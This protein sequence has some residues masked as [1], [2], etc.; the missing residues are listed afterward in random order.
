MSKNISRKEFFKTFK[1]S[2]SAASERD[3]VLGSEFTNIHE[4][5]TSFSD[6][7]IAIANKLKMRRGSWVNETGTSSGNVT[8][9][10]NQSKCKIVIQEMEHAAV[11]QAAKFLASDIMEISGFQPAIYLKADLSDTAPS[12]FKL[13]QPGS[14]SEKDTP[15]L[16]TEKNKSDATIY[17]ATIDDNK[18]PERINVEEIKDKWEGHQV[19]TNENAVWLVGADFRGTAFAAYVF[20]E[21]I[22]VD[23]LYLWTG[24]EPK[25]RKTLVVK[26]IDYKASSPTFKFRGFFHDDEDILPRPFEDSGYPLRTGDIDLEWYKKYFETALRLRM[27][28]VAPYTRVHRRYEVQQC[29]SEWGLF[30]T[31]H[32]YDILLSNPFGF[33]IFKLAEK[34]NIKPE[35]NWFTNKEGMVDYWR[36]G[37]WEN[38][39]LDC[40]WPVGL[41]GLGDRA[42][43]FPENATQKEQ[44]KVFT[45]VISTQVDTVNEMLSCNKPPVY[46]FTLYREMFEKY[47][48]GRES[49]NVPEDV[50]IVWSDNNAG[51][52]D[53]LPKELGKWKHGVYYHLAVTG[54]SATIQSTHIVNPYTITKE[55]KKVMDA[56]ATEY[57][58]INVSELREFVMESRLL[59]EIG[60]DANT[61]LSGDDPAGDYINWWINEYFGSAA[62]NDA[63]KVYEQYYKLLTRST[64]LW[65]AADV[66]WNILEQ[67]IKKFA[68]KTF[69]PIEEEVIQQLKYRDK[70]YQKA[71]EYYSKALKKIH[72]AQ[73]QYFFEN[74]GLGLC[75]DWRPTQAALL[76]YRAL[77][78]HDVNKA[79]EY[80]H[81]S[82]RPLEQLELE[83][84][85]AERAPFFD[86]YRETWI[87][88]TLSNHNVHRSYNILRA[89][90]AS[91]GKNF[92]PPKRKGRA[93]VPQYQA[94]SDF[95]DSQDNK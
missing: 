62:M 50:I 15:A 70:E 14:L 12:S 23:P 41:R 66:V 1:G 39:E 11:K 45:D 29:A 34:R 10:G 16:V 19:M 4:K 88:R 5:K 65:F 79:W 30:Y 58:L 53:K 80:I 32:H 56:G 93:N 17:L 46:T 35:W 57:L 73:Q 84:K 95:L 49:F 6:N 9:V 71:M 38:K 76:L 7:E 31:S 8:L 43:P 89:F 81:Q 28:M 69:K 13:F 75:F 94:W 87:R 68:G 3:N 59:A 51:G 55:F 21:R 47:N 77:E 85:K 40:V 42:Y 54:F 44:D 90:I 52:M 83:I 91:R 61:T 36:G 2:S 64:S 20:C 37:V 33:E 67:L 82:M 86:W 72:P 26:Q 78:D 60:W 18:I 92:L 63:T 24:Y 74:A 22:G 25:R 27:N 48:S